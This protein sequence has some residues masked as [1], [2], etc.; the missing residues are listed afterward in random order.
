MIGTAWE[1]IETCPP[2]KWIWCRVPHDTLWPD[3]LMLP[4]DPFFSFPSFLLPLA[5]LACA[6]PKVKNNL[7]SPRRKKVAWWNSADILHFQSKFFWSSHR[8]TMRSVVSLQCWDKGS[9]PNLAQW[10]KDPVLPQLWHR[11]QRQ[12]GSDPWPRNSV[13]CREAKKGEVERQKIK[14]K[15]QPAITKNK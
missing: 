5:E 7:H 12:L 15:N 11:L 3:G 6:K 14:K 8:G 9:I 1:N 10:V 13:C 4:N 2:N